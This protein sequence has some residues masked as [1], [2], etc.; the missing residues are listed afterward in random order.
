MKK[1]NIIILVVMLVV[2][3]AS[4]STTLII[5][6]NLNL[7]YDEEFKSSVVYTR[8]ELENGK[9]EI[10]QNEQNIDFETE[11]LENVNQV[12]TLEFDVT[13][14]SRN[15]DASVT[16]ACGLKEDFKDFSE[17]IEVEMSLESPFLLESSET[18]TGYLTIKLKKAYNKELETRIEMSCK[19]VA[20]PIERD[21]LGDEYVFVYEDPVLKGTNPVINDGLIPVTIADNGEV[22]YADTSKEWYNYENKKWANAVILVEN[23][24]K[25]YKTGNIISESDI[26]SYFVW[27]PRYKYQIFNE[28][29]YT[30]AING[31]PTEESI[32]KEIQIEFETKDVSPSTG[33]KQGE[34][35]THPAFTNFDVNGIWVGKYETGYKG[36]SST[37]AA[38]VNATNSSKVI[39]KPNVYSWRYPTISNMFKTAYNYNRELDSHM[40]KNTEWGAVAYLSHSKYGI[41]TEVRINN[42][43]SH[44]TGYSATDGAD[45]SSIPSVFGTTS[46]VTLPY[47]TE[48]G[49]KASTTGNIT[50][51][52]DMS[53]G[54]EE[55]VAAYM[56]NK[57]D[58]SGFTSTELITYSKYFDVYQTDSSMT[59]YNH[60]ILGDATGEMGPFYYYADRDNAGRYHNNWYVDYS[61]FIDS[62]NP[63][64]RR[65]GYYAD[66]VL[67]GQFSFNRFAGGVHSPIGFR[68]VLT[69]KI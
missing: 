50:G 46:D 48:T 4:V 11:K 53:G 29:N 3:F 13:N 1:R 9:V 32:A 66:G 14:K 69:A 15:Y 10:N 16:I 19:L 30:S 54:A 24:S 56:P 44:L 59:S 38:Q 58:L 68:L 41:N 5:R 52:Y 18:K 43:S 36:A 27:I 67:A 60:R 21:T 55:Y 61:L 64:F 47:N 17:Y 22:T 39:I 23:P 42:N 26:E 6:G 65:G 33:S 12:T 45:Q 2:G 49:Y 34:W 63:W 28:G 31:K 37:E 25:E 62:T 51:V 35:L 20:T 8:A 40:M 57:K 7:G